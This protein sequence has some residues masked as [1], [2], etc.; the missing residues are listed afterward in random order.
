LAELRV[1]QKRPVYRQVDA[2]AKKRLRA[3]GS[4]FQDASGLLRQ[5]TVIHIKYGKHTGLS[6]QKRMK[7]SD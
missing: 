7:S 5:G 1:D 6:I 2:F 4:P 3:T